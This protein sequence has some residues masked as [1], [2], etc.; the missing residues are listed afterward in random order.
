[1][2]LTIILSH[3]GHLVLQPVSIDINLLLLKY[4]A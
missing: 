3:I 2:D 4:S 1:M